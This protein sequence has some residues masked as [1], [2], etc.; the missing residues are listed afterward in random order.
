[1]PPCRTLPGVGC[2]TPPAVAG[3]QQPQLGPP[4]CRCRRLPP[5]HPSHPTRNPRPACPSPEPQA[6][7]SAVPSVRSPEVRLPTPHASHGCPMHCMAA[8]AWHDCP[9]MAWLPPV[10]MILGAGLPYQPLRTRKHSLLRQA[11][12]IPQ[13]RTHAC[14]H[15]WASDSRMVWLAAAHVLPTSLPVR[16]PRRRPLC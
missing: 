8:H 3:G 5:A 15:A 7:S 4:R 1:M 10:R 6:I 2:A 14:M 11:Y 9:C 12:K 16:W 13:A